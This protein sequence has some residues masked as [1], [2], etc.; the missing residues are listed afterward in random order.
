MIDYKYLSDNYENIVRVE[1]N[2]VEIIGYFLSVTIWLSSVSY[3]FEMWDRLKYPGDGVIFHYNATKFTDLVTVHLS[4]NW[5]VQ[6]SFLAVVKQQTI[7]DTYLKFEKFKTLP[8][9]VIRLSLWMWMASSS[10]DEVHEFEPNVEQISTHWE[11]SAKSKDTKGV[12]LTHHRNFK[13]YQQQKHVTEDGFNIRW[14]NHLVEVFNPLRYF[15]LATIVLWR[16]RG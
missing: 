5:L 15:L 10:D 14:V 1:Q 16:K 12:L 9:I 7:S 13:W 3:R 2:C 4:W 11:K 6:T 8:L